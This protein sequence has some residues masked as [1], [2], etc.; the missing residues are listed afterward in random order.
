MLA[1]IVRGVDPV[2]ASIR[3]DNV[4]G[5]VVCGVPLAIKPESGA[6]AMNPAGNTKT[7]SVRIRIS[8]SLIEREPVSSAIG[9]GVRST[10]GQ[11]VRSHLTHTAKGHKDDFL[12]TG[13]APEVRFRH[14]PVSS[15]TRFFALNADIARTSRAAVAGVSRVI[16]HFLESFHAKR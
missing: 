7:E 11:P 4:A 10:I 6:S 13:A 2:R 15:E 14:L 3:L 1:E 16:Q 5:A 12:H 8:G 9:L